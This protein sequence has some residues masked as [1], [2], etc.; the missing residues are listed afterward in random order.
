MN[1][2]SE[3]LALVLIEYDELPQSVQKSIDYDR[4]EKEYCRMKGVLKLFKI[5]EKYLYVYPTVF[6]KSLLTSIYG[7]RIDRINEDSFDTLMYFF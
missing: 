7:T 5:G 2:L 4:E 3:K 1:V 6:T